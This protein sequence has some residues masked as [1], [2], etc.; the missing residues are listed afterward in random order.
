MRGDASKWVGPCPKLVLAMALHQ[1][2]Q[3]DEARKTLAS[4][5]LSHDWT[6]NQVRDIEGCIAHLL[7]REAE[8]MILPNLPAFLEG[9]YQP[10][11][12]DERLALLGACQFMNR[13]RA[14]ARLYANAFAAAPS[15][16]RVAPS[17]V[18]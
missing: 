12:N 16:A 18:T 1:K 14:M 6:A 5:V 8:N 17:P 4:A 11:D 7:R 15:L 3:A 13:S 10:R 2:G 9:K